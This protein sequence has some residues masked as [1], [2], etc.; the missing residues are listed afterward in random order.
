[1]HRPDVGSGRKFPDRFVVRRERVK[2]P[3]TRP[4]F[5]GAEDQGG[6]SSAESLLDTAKAVTDGMT[7]CWGKKNARGSTRIR[8]IRFVTSARIGGFASTESE[9]NAD[10]FASVGMREKENAGR[11]SQ[12]PSKASGTLVTS[13]AGFMARETPAPV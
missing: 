5:R 10:T 3:S 2:A 4:A 1:M 7:R 8:T 11:V 13:S 6:G 9:R 12:I